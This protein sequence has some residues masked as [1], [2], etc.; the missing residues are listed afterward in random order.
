MFKK[1][2]IKPFVAPEEAACN[3]KKLALL[4]SCIVGNVGTKSTKAS[5]II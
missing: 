2:S 3:H 4:Q 5:S 1:N